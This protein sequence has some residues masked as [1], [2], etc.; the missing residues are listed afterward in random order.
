MI[1]LISFAPLTAAQALQPLEVQSEHDEVRLS[2]IKELSVKSQFT[3]REYRIQIAVIGP[4]PETGYPA[5]LVLDGDAYFTGVATMANAMASSRVQTKKTS[6]LLV[7]VG[8]SDQE[9]IHI[10]QRSLDFTPPLRRGASAEEQISFGQ[11]DR[12][13]QFLQKE[14][15]HYLT[16]HYFINSKHLAL[17]GHSFGGLYGLYD[18]FQEEP[19]FTYYILSSPSVWWHDKRILDFDIN[20]QQVSDKHLKITVGELEGVVA[21]ADVRRKSRNMMGNAED[22]FEQLKTKVGVVEFAVYPNESHG[23]VAYKSV[24]DSLKFLQKHLP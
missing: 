6:L 3:N 22:L 23:S 11:A 1:A 4:E 17:F 18:L 19:L 7:G 14:L 2:F 20:N 21:D 15:I 5:L 13:Y 9:P 10:E 12:F 16:E 24:L 8:Y